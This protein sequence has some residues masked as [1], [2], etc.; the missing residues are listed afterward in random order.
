MKFITFL[1][2]I[3]FLHIS[4]PS[5]SQ[6]TKNKST[7]G[8]FKWEYEFPENQGFSS[9]KLKALVDSLAKLGT[10][11]L[12]II[13]ND[14][15]VCE[16]FAPG[17]HDS[18][19]SHYS[20]SLAKA[21]VSGLSLALALNDGYLSPDEPVCDFIP[22]WKKED[23]KSKITIRQLAT[24]TSGIEDAEVSED[25]QKRMIAEGRNPHMDIPGW[26][27]SFWHQDKNPFLL[28]RDSARV[29]F[30]P[31]TNF[32]YSNPGIALLNYVVTVSLKGSAYDNIK[33]YL[34]ERI[35]NP[36][37]IKENEYS[38][39]Y[40]KIFNTEGLQ[41]VAGWGGG[42]FTANA[43]A[44]IGRL[45]LN[46]GNWQGVQIIDSAI[47]DEVTRY[48]G[49][50][51]PEFDFS[52]SNDEMTKNNGFA[53]TLGWY[54]N[55]DGVWDYLP[56]GSFGGAGA[57]N[58]ML[59]VI[60]ELNMIIV[61]FGDNLIKGPDD[62]D[63]FFYRAE[64]YLFNPIMEAF[65]QPPYP[66]SEFI[67]SVQFEP[68][69][70]V[71]RLANGSDNW[72]ATWADDGNI[73]T[74]YGDGFGFEPKTDIK[75]SLGIA[76]VEG[77][78]PNIKGTNIR[79]STGERVGQGK[80]GPK[81]SGM[82]MVDGVLY[83]LAR[84]AGNAQLA[85]SED[86]GKTWKWADWRFDESFGCPTFLNYGKNYEGARDHFVYV[87]SGNENSAYKIADEMVLARV[88]MNQIRNKSAYTYF[89]GLKSGAPVWSEDVNRR[90]P[91]FTNP[92][93]CYR[94]GISYNKGLEKYI[95]CQILPVFSGE[96]LQGPRFKGG[97]GIFESD[98]P[99]GPW[100]TVYYSLDW[101]IGPGETATIPTKWISEDGRSGYLLFSGNDCFSVRKMTFE[102]N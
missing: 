14:K 62:E 43:V 8:S 100:K 80:Y 28:A 30:T 36:I 102:M 38:L 74:A 101:D 68:T 42:N 65:I 60:P 53:P 6:Q 95:W 63:Q 89:I 21:V 29:L 66:K 91:V 46:K 73:Y 15:I 83:M 40:N 67:K 11:K 16:W 24:H 56:R 23:I 71:I 5:E 49:N 75:L 87:Y 69:N 10:K 19:R 25:E 92:G 35:F 26:K 57:G 96:E 27:G 85:W 82:L 59:M 70:S 1:F 99:W 13:R 50:N 55:H 90:Q 31:G 97:L 18:L 72:P 22:E 64:K 61:R 94:S 48:N 41:L 34:K 93:R 47:V 81:A 39:G 52:D 54:C 17:F 84:N 77:N 86:H 76:K 3:G 7:G 88:P 44:R 9:D 78:P 51:L 12:L 98:N 2:I 4:I 45:M 32:A 20:A 37:G 58:Q 79:S 33:S